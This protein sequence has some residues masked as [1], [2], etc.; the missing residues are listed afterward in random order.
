METGNEQIEKLIRDAII[1]AMADGERRLSTDSY[2]YNDSWFCIAQYVFN[3]LVEEG[4][5]KDWDFDD[6]YYIWSTHVPEECKEE[7]IKISEVESAKEPDISEIFD[8]DSIPLSKLDEAYVEYEPLDDEID[9]F[10]LD[11]DDM[12]EEK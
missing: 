6:D 4:I 8:L 3:Q 10:S 11:E 12:N 9:F 1:S 7:S 5:I 2:W